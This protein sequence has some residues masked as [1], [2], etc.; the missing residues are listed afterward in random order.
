MG[1]ADANPE[2]G[3]SAAK[4]VTRR[5]AVVLRPAGPWTPAVHALLRHLEQAGF[6]AA[7]RLSGSGLAADGR[8]ALCYVEGELVHP[9]PWRDDAAAEVGRLLRRLHTATASFRPAPGHRWQPW[10]LREIGGGPRVISHGDLAPWNIITRGG[11]PVALVDWEYAGPVA[12]LTE[13]ARVCWLTAQLHDDDVA[14]LV[15]LPPLAARAR[16]LRCIADAYGASAA[17]RRALLPRIIEVAVR[18]TAQEAID[19]RLTPDSRDPAPLW[20]LAWRARAAGWMLRH[21]ATL[22]A[23]LT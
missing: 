16:Q 3:L 23:A 19:A 6:A 18:E 2:T 20:G 12:P 21:R 11:W 4:A 10:F 9:G 1:A 14:A 7:P 8:E 15:H 17:Q 22:G 13:L 5:G